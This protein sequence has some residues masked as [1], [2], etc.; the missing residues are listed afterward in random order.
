MELVHNFNGGG[1]VS[2]LT[3]NDY[4][5]TASPVK[6]INDDYDIKEVCHQNPCLFCSERSKIY[7]V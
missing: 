1:G 6:D 3:S 2:G 5:P 7:W 4:V